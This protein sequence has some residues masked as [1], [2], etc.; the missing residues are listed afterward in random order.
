MS[1]ATP[2][3][4]LPPLLSRTTCPQCW[5]KFA[6]EDA[7]WIGE[8]EDL[9]NL[10]DRVP[11]AQL[12]FLPSRFTAHGEARDPRGFPCH[13]LACPSCHLEIPRPILE[14][15]GFFL[16]VI[17]CPGSGK[18]YFLAAMARQ[19][20]QVLP[21]KFSIA[22]TDSDATLNMRLREYE[23][24]LFANSRPD[25]LQELQELIRKTQETGDDF[26]YA[27]VR[28]GT[29]AVR[30]LR[31][32]MFS[33]RAQNDHPNPRRRGHGRT[34]CVYDNAGESFLPGQDKAA[35][36]V[37]RHLRESS[38]LFFVFDPLQ[39][40]RFR[41]L[42]P[43]LRDGI[44]DKSHLGSQ[45]GVFQEAATR[46]RQLG[47]SSAHKDKRPVIVVVTKCDRWVHHADRAIRELSP[48]TSATIADADG[49]RFKSGAV[50]TDVVERVS[51]R[52]R[53]LLL[54]TTPEVVTAVESF[55]DNVRYVPVSATGWSTR[56]DANTGRPLIRPGEVE[57]FWADVP[58]LYALAMSRMDLVPKVRRER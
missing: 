25:Q 39:D 32:F 19:L 33:M 45:E 20:R 35:N 47:L 54:K 34:I 37:T 24:S 38:V 50:D 22:F 23:T 18:S 36:P 53:A 17:G 16:S 55:A 57:P 56:V 31:P 21:L 43:E 52:L 6:P 30:Y 2:S 1:T 4:Q 14:L 44:V 58:F 12:R 48:V 46:I 28:Y 5:H 42:G 29:Q 9:F 49:S 40:S 11:N 13:R 3:R 7:L 15:D 8:H 41:A 27:D 26:G 10:D 51:K